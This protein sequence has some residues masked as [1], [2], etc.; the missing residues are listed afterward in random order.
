VTRTKSPVIGEPPGFSDP[1]RVQDLRQRLDEAEAT[2]Q[3]LLSGQI[4][5]VVDAT[6]GTPVLLAKAQEAL[7][8]SEERYREQAALLDIAH[9][10]IMVKDLDGR[11]LYWNK[12]AE[13]TFGWSAAETVGRKA[14]D[15]LFQDVVQFH[16]A[17]TT[18]L[19]AG[20]WT[21]E[22]VRQ[23]KDGHNI[24]VESGW[25]LVRD[26]QGRPKSILAIHT[27]ITERKRA[28]QTLRAAEERVRFALDTANV[29]I[30]DMDC[31]T[32]AIKWSETLEAQYGLQSGEFGGTFEQFVELIHPDDRACVI[33]AI[34][35]AMKS[36][37]DFSFP[38]R[39]P[40][41][42][43]P[44]QWLTNAGRFFIG[45]D[46]HPLRGVGISQN[47]TERRTLER[48]YQQAQKMEAIGQLASGVAHDFNNL[49]T[50]IHGFAEFVAE[51]AGLDQRH[52]KDLGEIIKA[53]ERAAAL[54]KQLLAFSRQ[55][56][57][58]TAPVD[59]N[60]LLTEMTGMLGRLIGEDIE[61]SL[62]LAPGLSLALADRG[63][64]EQVVMNLVVNARDAMPGGGFVTIET[65]N[66]ELEN[67]SFLREAVMQGHYVMLS[68]TDTGSGM[69]EETKKHLF[70]PFFTTKESGKGT[71]LGL[72]T[73][74]GI[75][76]QS[77][78][79]IWV[80]T[81]L[82]HG[83]TFKVYLPLANRE[84]TEATVR[85]TVSAPIKRTSQTVLLVE[86]E[87]AVRVLAKRILE[88]AGYRVLEAING[89]DAERVFA[90][91][92]DSIDLLV[93]DV[94]MPG[95]GGPELLTRLQHRSP[96]V[97]VLYMSGYT[98][99]SAAHKAGIDRGTP[100]VQKPFTAAEL[101]RQVREALAR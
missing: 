101:E 95:C 4:D 7:R 59:L 13:R 80:Y 42:D 46:G 50:V 65:T 100:F 90:Q 2:I 52:A 21:G 63:Q 1:R 17:R 70:E 9:E 47:V 41:R 85:T 15:F 48:Q 10:A 33:A 34:G 26:E 25:T 93:T 11:I 14:E 72:S 67:S 27:D 37:A 45:D 29:G 66:V 22:Q 40:W 54:T 57:L 94:V 84:A 58:Q 19:A 44:V 78:G 24:V 49:L 79:Y 5:A 18:L 3:A 64:L 88:N 99:Q 92:A 77:N 30:W 82:G 86:D 20:D 96:A 35:T 51:D 61:I 75:V 62:A 71:G 31:A 83:T 73:T 23:T 56:V 76:K 28:E 32:G 43:G 6:N 39:A 55:Q 91:H 60:L 16:K 81:E 12:G 87:A 74:Y 69:T 53:A 98:E 89:N 38:S 68:V 8:Q 36:G 97:R